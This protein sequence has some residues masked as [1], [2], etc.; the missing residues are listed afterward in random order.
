MKPI[1]L[2]PLLSGIWLYLSIVGACVMGGVTQDIVVTLSAIGILVIAY[3]T[4]D[5]ERYQTL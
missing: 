1:Y 4:T 2:R 3:S 5:D